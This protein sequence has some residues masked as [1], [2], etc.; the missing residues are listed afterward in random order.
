M[1]PSNRNIPPNITAT[2]N[3]INPITR[4]KSLFLVLSD[5]S[6]SATSDVSSPMPSPL[7]VPSSPEIMRMKESAGAS[8]TTFPSLPR[9]FGNNESK[10]LKT[11]R[12]R[13]ATLC[14][15]PCPKTL[16][17]DE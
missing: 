3:T 15:V 12:V 13:S 11:K 1:Y 10:P 2:L 17:V 9:M 16:T 14:C 7:F 6:S 4:K 8:R 5:F